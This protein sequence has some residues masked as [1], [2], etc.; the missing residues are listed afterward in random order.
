MIELAQGLLA[1]RPPRGR[2]VG[3]VGDGGG[4]VALAADLVTDYGL[5]LPVLSEKVSAGIAAHLPSNAATGNPVDLAGGGEEDFFNYSKVVTALAASGEVDAVMLTGYFG[6]YSE[7]EAQLARIE[8]EVATAM[9]DVVGRFDATLIV[10]SMYPAASTLGALRDAGVPIYGDTRSAALVLS[11][12]VHRRKSTGLPLPLAGKDR[13]MASEGYFAARALLSAA[14]VPFTEAREVSSAA[15]AREAAA[16]IGYPVVLKAMGAEHKSDSG[17][18]RLGIAGEAEL[19]AALALMSAR[20]KTSSFSVEPMVALASGIELLI[21]ARRDRSFG[22]IVLI[23]AG[24]VYAELLRDV[25]VALAPVSVEQADEMIRSLRIAPM[26]LGSRGGGTLDVRA[27]ARA[28]AAL[29]RFAAEHVDVDEVEV[30][31]L[32]VTAEGVL[33]LDARI[34]TA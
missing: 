8:A 13:P 27:A 22:P 14:G 23:G 34:A 31:P 17:G 7:D 2:R 21:G 6:G 20:L 30:N 28:A 4:H 33:A 15:S 25:A 11:R 16:E 12:L 1:A 26:L 29:S 9:A 10:Q 24:G 32:L 3:I 19:E 5:E 18:V